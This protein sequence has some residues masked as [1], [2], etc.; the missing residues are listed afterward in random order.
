MLKHK[1]MF[2]QVFKEIISWLCAN[3]VKADVFLLHYFCTAAILV[4]NLVMGSYGVQ[5]L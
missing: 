2:I 5:V 4:S 1:N 3:I